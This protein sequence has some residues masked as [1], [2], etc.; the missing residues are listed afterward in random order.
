MLNIILFY[1]TNVYGSH[2]VWELSPSSSGSSI[3]ILLPYSFCFAIA[4]FIK[5][6]VQ[7]LLC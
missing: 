5:V 4:K 1:L 2:D 3:D 7:N 6:A